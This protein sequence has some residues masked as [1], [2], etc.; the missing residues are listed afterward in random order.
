M[1]SKFLDTAD[2]KIVHQL[3]ESVVG[4][5][6]DPP[7]RVALVHTRKDEERYVWKG[8]GKVVT[9]RQIVRK[10]NG[11]YALRAPE[12]GKSRLIRSLYAGY[13]RWRKSF[14]N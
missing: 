4:V 11:G 2:I 8:M 5:M 7:Q 14:G 1:R 13:R 6:P 12:F 10:R 3:H 9:N